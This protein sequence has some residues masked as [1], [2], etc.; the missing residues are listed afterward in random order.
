MSGTEGSGR[1]VKPLYMRQEELAK[2]KKERVGG[3]KSLRDRG[4]GRV[5]E[6]IMTRGWHGQGTPSPSH[7]L[8]NTVP[9]SVASH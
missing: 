6:M 2:K 4:E 8:N 5:R 1:G 7:S 3:E 9:T